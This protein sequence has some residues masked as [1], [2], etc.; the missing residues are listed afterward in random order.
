[1]SLKLTAIAKRTEQIIKS[2]QEPGNAADPSV[3]AKVVSQAIK[4]KKP[5]TRYVAGK[6]AK[7]LVWLRKFLGERIFDRIVMSL[8]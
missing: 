2:Y 5:K 3:I 6:H 4:V 7:L 8:Y 1:M